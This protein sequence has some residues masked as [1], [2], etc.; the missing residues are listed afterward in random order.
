VRL[1]PQ[2]LDTTGSDVLKDVTSGQVDAGL[3]FKTD[4]LNV[5]DNVSWFAFPEAADASV[6]S[7]IAPMKDSTQAELAAKFIHDVT[8]AAG[9]KVLA[10]N[11]FAEPAKG[12]ES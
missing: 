3:V 1:H 10:D 2:N 8:G 7:W 6:T 5:G 11:G 4:A 12:F 9:R